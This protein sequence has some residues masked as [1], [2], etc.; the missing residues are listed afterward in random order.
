MNLSNY[1]KMIDSI[2]LEV[3]ELNLNNFDGL[4]VDETVYIN[5][6]LTEREKIAT[7]TEEVEHYNLNVGDITNTNNANNRK[8]EHRAQI[9]ALQKLVTIPNL[10][11][12]YKSGC[13]SRYEIAEFL[14]VPEKILIKAIRILSTKFPGW[15]THNEFMISLDPLMVIEKR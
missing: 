7:L 13:T 2:P 11:K 9:S 12:A 4:I 5:K 6:N 8:Q 14:D 1:E 15:I 3:K 10:I